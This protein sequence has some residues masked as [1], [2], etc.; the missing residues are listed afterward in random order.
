MNKSN[1]LKNLIRK[2]RIDLNVAISCNVSPEIINALT[3]A[4]DELKSALDAEIKFE[5][6][7]A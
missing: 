1:V 2:L 5:K 3:F 4:I 6:E 7:N